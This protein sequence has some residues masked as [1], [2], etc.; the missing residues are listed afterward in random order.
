L[1]P[2]GG[3]Q[4]QRV[5]AADELVDDGLLLAAEGGVA[6]DFGENLAGGRGGSRAIHG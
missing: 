3:H 2:A 1:A 4:H 6:E 5:A